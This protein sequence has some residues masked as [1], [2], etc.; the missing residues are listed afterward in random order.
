MHSTFKNGKGVITISK[1]FSPEHHKKDQILLFF[2]GQYKSS[3]NTPENLEA[4]LKT[5]KH[6]YAR[7]R[8]EL[9]S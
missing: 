2:Q 6:N 4:T 7:W 9:S 8:F 1:F 3:K 5:R